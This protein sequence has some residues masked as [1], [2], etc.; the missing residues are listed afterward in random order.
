MT[1]HIPLMRQPAFLGLWGGT[2]ASGLATWGLVFLLGIAVSEGE[3][4]ARSL[5]VFL[6]LRS[7]G[8]LIGV[9]FGGVWADGI[10][11][12]RVIFYSGVMA[13]AG[14]AL[15]AVTMAGL[16][17][18]LIMGV[19]IAIAGAGQGA[20]RPAYQALLPSV[21]DAAQRQ[22]ANAT[23][24]LS[25]NSALLAAPLVA[26]A[27]THLVGVAA[28]LALVPV[29]W[30][31]SALLPPWVAASAPAVQRPPFAQQIREGIVEA[32]RH[33]WFFPLLAALSATIAFGFSVNGVI[34][35]IMSGNETGGGRLLAYAMTG[36]TLGGLAGAAAVARFQIR[37]RVLWMSIGL[38][39]FAFAPLSLLVPKILAIPVMGYVLAGFGIQLFNVLW[40]THMQSEVAPDK[41][42]RVSSLDF[43][44]SFGLAPLGLALIGPLADLIGIAALLVMCVAIC[45]FGPALAYRYVQGVG[46]SYNHK[47]VL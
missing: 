45:A 33:V 36:F 2:T 22:R 26:T 31:T 25:L 3:L 46:G 7:I 9:L 32:R 30:I 19:G 47:K 23:L 38:A 12:R 20:C 35:P 24:S 29:L 27:A 43:L 11:A 28:A 37:N 34:L 21:V 13:C 17:G 16:G 6:A 41:L 1:P 8:F 14:S 18:G 10:G 15:V 44:C 39:C 5:G 40:F 4:S 42:A